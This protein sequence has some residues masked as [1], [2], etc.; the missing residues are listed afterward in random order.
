MES[1]LPLPLDD[2]RSNLQKLVAKFEAD[3]AHYLSKSYSEAQA[4]VDFISPFFKALGWD[5]ENEAGLPHHAR[6]VLVEKTEE[7]TQGKPDYSFRL[8][9]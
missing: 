7:E 2:F 8:G 6:E 3:K 1:E 4:R 5:V 9:G